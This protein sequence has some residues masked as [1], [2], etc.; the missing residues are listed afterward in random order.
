MGGNWVVSSISESLE[1]AKL[2][3]QMSMES[4]EIS[5]ENGCG[6]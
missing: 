6:K 5:S 1:Q 3:L 2:G 4:V